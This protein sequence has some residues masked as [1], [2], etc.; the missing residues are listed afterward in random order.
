ME[1]HVRAYKEN[2]KSAEPVGKFVTNRWLN[3]TMGYCGE[4]NREARELC[5]RSLKTFFGPDKPY[6]V[7]NRAVYPPGTRGC[8]RG[9][10]GRGDE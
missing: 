6:V 7:G 4:D 9:P 3:S 2:V 5:A 10:P 1:P 8:P